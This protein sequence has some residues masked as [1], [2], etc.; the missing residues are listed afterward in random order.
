MIE[1]IQDNAEAYSAAMEMGVV[2]IILHDVDTMKEKGQEQGVISAVNAYDGV[3]TIVQYYYGHKADADNGWLIFRISEVTEETAA[4]QTERIIALSME[5]EGEK[6]DE[7]DLGDMP[8]GPDR[9]NG[10]LQ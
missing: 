1:K 5:G 6:P 4:Y 9:S 3:V 7:E 2:D 8:V 10:Q